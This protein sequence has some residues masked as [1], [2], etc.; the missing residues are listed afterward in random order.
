MYH[1]DGYFTRF[2][3]CS[4][5]HPAEVTPVRRWCGDCF[6]PNHEFTHVDPDEVTGF[7]IRPERYAAPWAMEAL[8]RELES[9]L[10]WFEE[11]ESLGPWH[12]QS[13]SQVRDL[14]T[15]SR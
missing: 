4:G 12:I 1:A 9:Q 15:E 7:Q 10:W 11:C 8:M 2:F 6:D 3:D 13:M 14:S 5:E